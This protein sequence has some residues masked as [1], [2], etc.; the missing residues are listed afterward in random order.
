MDIWRI[1]EVE[2][3]SD[4]SVIKKAY[5]QKLKQTRPDDDE[6]AFIELR[7]AYEE[8]LE[9]AEYYEEYDEEYDEEY[10]EYDEELYESE[11]TQEFSEI[12]PKQEAVIRRELLLEE[13]SK[14]LCEFI[15]ELV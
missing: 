3:T 7:N 14:A 15:D 10:E 13:W 11:Y 2:K 6:K 12:S 8:A 4:K 5:R 1:L 9:Y